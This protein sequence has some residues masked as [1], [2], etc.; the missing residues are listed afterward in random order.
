MT[1][2]DGGGELPEISNNGVRLE[3][4]QVAKGRQERKDCRYLEHQKVRVVALIP[5]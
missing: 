3:K 2:D 5:C 4:G 1:F